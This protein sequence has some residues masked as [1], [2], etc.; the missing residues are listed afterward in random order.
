M[1]MHE[2]AE[3][4]NLT[5]KIVAAYTTK[6]PVGIAEL[7]DLIASVSQNLATVGREGITPKLK[8]AVPIK[9]SVT[10]AHITC[11]EDGKR[12]KMI[13]RHL[14]VAHQM[15]PEA[16]RE[17]WGLAADYPMTS[18]DYSAQRSTLAK[19]IGLGKQARRKAAARKMKAR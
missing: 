10:R 15:T 13:K 1:D 7:P 11:L 5:T 16:Y 17:K 12:H 9:K 2:K 4:L 14:R 19:Q 8:P 3:L 6:N 18:P